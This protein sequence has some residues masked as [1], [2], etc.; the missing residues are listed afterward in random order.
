VTRPPLN[1]WGDRRRAR[2]GLLGGSFNPAHAGHRHIAL[3]ALGLL[4]LDEVWLLV[5]PQ[6]PLKPVEGM[7]PLGQRLASAEAMAGGHPAL[8]PTAMETAWGT[9]YTAHTL[10][11]LRRRFPRIRFVWLMGADN[12]AG[13]HRWFRWDDIFRSVPVAILARG[14]YSARILGSRAAHRF[15]ASRL[16]SSR[17]RFLWQ[18]RPPAWVF[19]H[20][21]RHAASS[22]AIRNRRE[23]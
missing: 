10:D 16:P 4:C 20:I 17:A 23:P 8:R 3:R 5:S 1:P 11:M 13:F 18:G 6:N 14:P 2:I 19:L 22:T 12:L 15:K 9:A 21:R 7:A